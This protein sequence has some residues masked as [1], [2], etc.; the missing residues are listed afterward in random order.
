MMPVRLSLAALAVLATGACISLDPQLPKTDPQ[1]AAAFP[2]PGNADVGTPPLVDATLGSMDADV[3][4]DVRWQDFYTDPAL[5]QL[6]GAA[7]VNNRDL[8]VAVLNVERARALYGVQ[9]ADLVPSLDASGTGQRIGTDNSAVPETELYT[10]TLGVTA[11][12]L[13]LFGRVRSLTGAALS[14]YLAQTETRAAVQLS[15]VAEVANTWLTLAADKDLLRIARDTLDTQQETYRIFERQHAAGYISGLDLEQART[16]LEAARADVAQYASAVE[17]DGNA[18]ALVVGAPVDPA[19]LPAGL[20]ERP[21]TTAALPVG[22]PSEVLLRRPDVRA[23]ELQLKAA[24]ANIGAARAAFFPRVTLTGS[25]GTAST[26]LSGLFSAGSSYWTFVPQISI[27]IFA[28]GRLR[29]ELD[30]AKTDRDIA[31]AQYEQSVQTGFREVADALSRN[32]WLAQQ[33]AAREALLTAASRADELALA[34]Y[35][36]GLD[37]YVTSLIAH[38]TLYLAQQTLVAVQLAEVTN[39]VTLYRS[40]GG[41]WSPP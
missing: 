10:A 6:I 1:V 30:V 28:G 5:K 38:R 15:L 37:S 23:A 29:S 9:R 35:K 32:A 34:R 18:L 17:L 14:R 33:R 8:R 20:A 7:L 19:L 24:N 31:L 16:E 3:G 11:F 25:A 36:A 39:H 26:E 21:M 41:G 2:K 13:D 12:E 4:T 27:P 22:L 40:L